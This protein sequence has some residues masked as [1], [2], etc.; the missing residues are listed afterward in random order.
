MV[1]R[2]TE[3]EIDVVRTNTT[4]AHAVIEASVEPAL[5]EPAR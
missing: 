4:E 5:Y 3:A 1:V 2:A